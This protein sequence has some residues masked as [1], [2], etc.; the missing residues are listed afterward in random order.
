MI[1]RDSKEG[2]FNGLTTVCLRDTYKW[3][4]KFEGRIN[5]VFTIGCFTSELFAILWTVD[6]KE[7]LTVDIEIEYINKRKEE[8]EHLSRIIPNAFVNRKV[9]LLQKNILENIPKIPHNYF[10]MAYCQN[11][12]YNFQ[13]NQDE[14]SKA[15][16][17]MVDVIKPGGLL[18]AE[19][20]KF[21]VQFITHEAIVNG[22]N[23]GPTFIPQNDPIDMT[24]TFDKN[25]QIRKILENGAPEWSY[26]YK[27]IENLE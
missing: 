5:K 4:T 24:D 13:D 17:L 23:L 9:E 25:G 20:P 7:I 8:F 11:V 2:W 1:I 22:I 21:G 26:C 15:I 6:A 12:L 27:K 16:K 19:E 18:I 14:L 10:D 3:L